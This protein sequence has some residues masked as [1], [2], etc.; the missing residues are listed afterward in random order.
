MPHLGTDAFDQRSPLL[1][2]NSVAN[3]HP[4]RPSS[5][6]ASGLHPCL[7]AEEDGDVDPDASHPVL[8][9]KV[10]ADAESD[11]QDHRS[12]APDDAEHRQEAA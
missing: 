2:G 9:I 4:D 3:V 7:A 6:V 5:R 11:Q 12:D 10:E 1:D 8:L